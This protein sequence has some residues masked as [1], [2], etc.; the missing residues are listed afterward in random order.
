[1]IQELAFC[2]FLPTELAEKFSRS[3]DPTVRS[4]LASCRNATEATLR[5]LATDSEEQ[6]RRSIAKK[7]T[8]PPVL[9]LLLRDP[10]ESVRLGL[11]ENYQL[12]PE[13]L[14]RFSLRDTPEVLTTV[15]SHPKADADIRTRILSNSRRASCNIV[16]RSKVRPTPKFFARIKRLLSPETLA[17]IPDLTHIAP[18]I[19]EN[20]SRSEHP[21][22]RLAVAKRLHHRATTAT[23][24][25]IEIANRLAKDPFSDVRYEICTDPRLEA[26]AT[27]AL[28]SDPDPRIRKKS[29]AAV[30]HYLVQRRNDHSL[31][32][33]AKIHR[34]KSP[35]LNALVRDPDHAVRYEIAKC[36]EA[37][38]EALGILFDDPVPH[39]AEAAR[40]HTRWPYGVLLD[41]ADSRKKPLESLRQGHTT[42]NSRALAHLA[43]SPNP[44]LRHL[45]ARCHRTPA[46]LLEKLATDPHPQ[47][48]ETATLTLNK[49]RRK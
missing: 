42:P 41:L 18:A 17:G 28:F 31:S 49:R 6:V 5:R 34:A 27:A 47:I 21:S 10:S 24:L 36:P 15:Y 43:Q 14:A 11:A 2:H 22:V 1:M 38:P 3:P 35:L 26:E 32:T 44:F 45:V 4:A 48:R 25:N 29:A 7:A 19:I 40:K 37:P 20:L 46:S 33:Y 39:I 8:L 12:P 16:L 9:E 23:K 13:L 30:L